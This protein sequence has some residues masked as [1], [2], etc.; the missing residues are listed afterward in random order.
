VPSSASKPKPAHPRWHPRSPIDLLRAPAPRRRLSH[1]APE[2]LPSLDESPDG[3]GPFGGSPSSSFSHR[4]PGASAPSG[5]GAAGGNG[6]GKAPGALFPP[7]APPLPEVLAPSDV[8][9]LA[10]LLKA[11][12]D[13]SA[14]SCSGQDEMKGPESARLPRVTVEE[15]LVREAKLLQGMPNINRVRL[16]EGQRLI[17]VGDIHGQLADLLH[18][19]SLCGSSVAKVA[20][21]AASY[22]RTRPWPARSAQRLR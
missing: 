15:L 6:A 5:N 1:D 10:G 13:A 7:R 14:A 16:K 19:F 17:V 20:T 18:I 22:R 3:F 2:L 4:P 9:R 8:V 11:A 12:A 21:P